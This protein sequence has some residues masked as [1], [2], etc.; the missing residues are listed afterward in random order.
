MPRVTATL[1]LKAA[2]VPNVRG[3]V[4]YFSDRRGDKNFD[5]RY[6]MEDVFPGEDVLTDEDIDN[7]GTILKAS[8]SDG[9]APDTDSTVG[10]GYAA[11]TDHSYYRRGVR[12]INGEKLP[13]KYDSVT[14]SKTTGF[15]LA[16][17]NGVYVWKN[18]NVS[19][20]TTTSNTTS[21]K[22]GPQGKT[23]SITGVDSDDHIPASIVGDAVTILSNN[24][25]D[26]KSFIYPNDLTKR[27]A[28]DT[29]VRFAMIAGDPITG[30]SPSEGLNGKQNGGLI[31]FKRFLEKWSGRSFKLFRLAHQS[32]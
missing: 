10:A 29:Q 26:T 28:T 15:T 11:V 20:V 22:Y 19:S 16:S 3:W 7:D 12:L 8:D 2:N 18:Y 23:D 6:N 24:W 27:V 1:P 14:N 30:K 32:L 5:G 25:N 21:D 4:L 17:E 31:N 13:G 9:E